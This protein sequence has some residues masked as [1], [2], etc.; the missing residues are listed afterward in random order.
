MSCSY[1]VR[2][3]ATALLVLFGVSL[4]TYGMIFLTP[5]SPAETI[6]SQQMGGQTPSQQAVEQF[7]QQHGLDEPFPVQYVNWLSDV[8]RGDLGE[9][10]YSDRSVTSMI[11]TQLPNTLELAVASMIVALVVG[12]PA[13]VVSGVHQNTAV[14]YLGQLGAL[15]GVAMPNFWLGY[16]L[17]IVFSSHL[18]LFPVAGAGGLDHLVLPALTLGT[19]MAAIIARVTRTTM[20]DVLEADYVRTARSKGLRERIVVY[21]HALRNALVPVVTVIGLQFG[22]V[23]DGAVIVEVVFQRPGLGKLLV[24]AVFA[25]NYP[26]VQGV[27]LLTGVLFVLTNLLVDLVY[28]RIDPRISRTVA[29]DA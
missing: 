11:L 16:L 12:L 26:V 22:Y 2:R 14:D 7:R 21:K 24:D 23:L 10:Y 15:A 19:S 29:I 17:I 28:R 20:L 4:A 13:G 27:V 5:G 8:L 9:S 6:L 25:R 1:A 18:G 3:F